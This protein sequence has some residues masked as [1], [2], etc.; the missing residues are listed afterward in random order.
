VAETHWYFIDREFM[1]VFSR[2][3]TMSFAVLVGWI[4]L[5]LPAGAEIVASGESHSC[6]LTRTGRVECWG[7]NDHG[8]LGDGTQVDHETPIAV[9]LDGYA[10]DLAVGTSHSCAL[11]SDGSVACWGSNEFGQ[12]GNGS[13][14][15]ASTPVNV[16]GLNAPVSAITAGP[17]F[18]CALTAAGRVKCWGDNSDWELGNGAPNLLL[19]ATPVDVAFDANIAVVGI[20]SSST[21]ASAESH[22]CAATSTGE[23]Y[24]WGGVNHYGELGIP[25]DQQPTKPAA[26]AGVQ[27]AVSL[28]VSDRH[29]CTLTSAGAVFCWG[30]NR[31]GQLGDATTTDRYAP[32][33]VVGL[34]EPVS[35]LAA[36]GGED[37]GVTCALT[38]SGNMLCWG[39]NA[40]GQLATGSSIAFSNVPVA[41]M[42]SRADGIAL[43]DEHGCARVGPGQYLCWGRNQ[44]GQIGNGTAAMRGT[45]R[46]VKG[47]DQTPAALAAGDSHTCA[48]LEDGSMTCWGENHHGQ[49]GDGSTERRLF[50]GPAIVADGAPAAAIAT[51][52]SHSCAISSGTVYC[53]G[54]NHF[55]QLGVG[56]ANDRFVPTMVI[57]GSAPSTL[58]AG[59]GF[60][61]ATDTEGGVQ[62]WGLGSDGELGDGFSGTGFHRTTPA[63]VTGLDHGAVAVTAGSSHACALLSDGAVKC[64]GYNAFGELGDGTQISSNVPVAVNSNALGAPALALAAGGQ[65]TCALLEGGAV[66]CW[67]SDAFGELGDGNAPV[68]Q[69]LPIAVQNLGGSAVSIAAGSH[70][71]CALLATGEV[72][73]WGINGSGQVG[74][75]T[76]SDRSQ[77]TLVALPAPAT[78]LAAGTNHNCAALIS[79]DVYCWGDATS[80]QLGSGDSGSWPSPQTVRGDDIFFD[81]FESD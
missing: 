54:Y 22:T 11:R 65:H 32:A 77:P 44:Y 7:R 71:T 5:A 73:C 2:L 19:S 28:A 60:T 37:E 31:A 21:S 9:S 40:Y 24:C 3:A 74:D 56:D 53:W 35:V 76:F 38:Q 27:N 50:P 61:C 14:T 33:P 10:V 29:S 18:T 80:G 42:I 26:V 70:H 72:K 68:S 1:R 58:S 47:L 67:G 39:S 43:G 51:G 52:D 69:A 64:W 66:K 59:A 36:G 55:G 75:S 57:L 20:A 30:R 6:A 4:S 63:P 8:Q 78:L 23:V 48:L 16:V 45:P 15:G 25:Q 12:L 41:T 46:R 34:N 17:L 79:G 13:Q 49:L 62:C 81:A